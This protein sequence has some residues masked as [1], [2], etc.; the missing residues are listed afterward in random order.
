MI[1]KYQTNEDF[2]SEQEIWPDL[3]LNAWKETYSYLHMLSQMV[4]KIRLQ[5]SPHINHWWQV[6]LYITARG[7]TTSTIPYV[8]RLFEIK[9]DFIN[10]QLI[11]ETNDGATETIPFTTYSVAEMYN[12]LIS[13]LQ[14]I[15]INVHIWPVP[16][17]M[18]N[19]I[20]FLQN[21]LPLKYNPTHANNFFRILTQTNRVFQQ[22][23]SNFIGKCSPIHFFWGSYDLAF[24]RFSGRKAP[25]HP[26]VP[27]NELSVVREAYSHE[28]S[29]CGFW[30][31]SAG[32]IQEPVFYSYSYPD[33]AEYKNFNIQPSQ[34]F[35]SKEIDEFILPYDVIKNSKNPDQDLLTFL[36]STY[37]AAAI[38]GHLDRT[39]LERFI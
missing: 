8:N 10:H 6:T 21:Q 9:F 2:Y 38:T 33:P 25:L 3:S 19:P 23:R 13:R 1:P 30:P 36:N 37:N 17:E 7:L 22:F 28:V 29:S 32:S 39:N 24:T 16:V 12:T 15:G 11:I 26:P 5:L 27:N 4:G 18:E 20:P 31:G 14:S 34:A 35:Y